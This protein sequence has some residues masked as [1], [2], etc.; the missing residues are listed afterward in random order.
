[1]SFFGAYL[2]FFWKG[3]NSNPLFAK[4]I[5]IKGYIS[6]EALGSGSLKWK[7]FIKM[8]YFWSFKLGATLIHTTLFAGEWPKPIFWFR[9][10]TKTKTQNG[11]CLV[12]LIW[13]YS[14]FQKYDITIP[15][16]QLLHMSTDKF[17]LVVYLCVC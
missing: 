8:L 16:V 13:L 10:D 3:H 4:K 1:M 15:F 2:V 7:P 5:E 17:G 11:L 14:S 9:S 12:I 6:L